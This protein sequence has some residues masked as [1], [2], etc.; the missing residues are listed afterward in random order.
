MKHIKYILPIIVLL[1]TNS[2]LFAQGDLF[3]F[4]GFHLKSVSG[5]IGITGESLFKKNELKGGFK[6]GQETFLVFGEFMLNTNSYF[7]H[8]NFMEL[9]ING[10]YRPSANK[11]NFIVIPNRSENANAERVSVNVNLLKTL[12]VTLMLNGSYGHSYTNRDKLTDIEMYSK[13]YGGGIS[14]RNNIL[15]LQINYNS[16]EWSQKEIL[17]KREFSLDSKMLVLN[18]NKN[19]GNYFDN[20][21][22][23][24]FEEMN[25]DYTG[26]NKL[27]TK[28]I[29]GNLNNNIYFDKLKINSLRSS[30]NYQKLVGYQQ[31]DRL[32]E[33]LNLN[34]ALPANFGFRAGYNISKF[35][36]NT[37][38]N[39][40][41]NQMA[42]L[43]H[44]LYLSLHSYAYLQNYKI[45]SDEYDEGKLTSA[46]GFNYKKITV[47]DGML[48][49][50]YE[51][52]MEK[53]SRTSQPRRNII[54]NEAI[55]LTDGRIILLRNPYVDLTSVIVRND[56]GSMVY[57]EN[58]D[59]QLI[60]HD[61]YIE[62]RRML[63]GMIPDGSTVYVD[64]ITTK[65]ESYKYDTYN[66]SFSLNWGI[67]KNLF[68]VYTNMTFN[69]Y[70]NLDINTNPL[71]NTINQKTFGVRSTYG[72][73][74]LGAE[75]Q[76]YKS[77]ILPYKST[78][79][80]L[81]F[82]DR[83]MDSFIFAF[84]SRYQSYEYIEDNTKQSFA[85]A[86]TNIEYEIAERSS[87]RLEASYSVQKNTGYNL[88]ILYFKGEYKIAFYNI[89]CS[90]G[91][92][93]YFRKIDKESSDFK[94]LFIKLE[95]KF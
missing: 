48:Y 64:Y 41:Q 50:N 34:I 95:R 5:S 53:N 1:L 21:I 84:D 44:Q 17:S 2:N 74:S 63:G 32:D 65:S 45:K 31:L 82:N 22:N 92:E 60:A 76:D 94:R 79:Y 11:E 39:T 9:S 25:T 49:I 23:V 80:F 52:R 77:T 91:G 93:T 83:I 13:G 61:A 42:N 43:D 36:Q 70:K 20:T 18:S 81:R 37:I 51:L 73:L 24:S 47:F 57:K 58:I 6:E 78:N 29:N 56:N 72:G 71:L 3:N 62:I 68:E 8:P 33:N 88:D 4:A 26:N 85:E 14:I 54:Q 46:I 28:S 66:N 86:S 90:A 89:Y 30:F 38:Q 69:N 35:T 55:K 7:W 15:P 75:M 59:Y 67:F 27:N 16:N 87:A 10:E 40:M 12:P 19:Y